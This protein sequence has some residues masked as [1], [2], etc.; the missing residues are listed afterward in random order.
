MNFI[1]IILRKYS[2]NSKILFTNTDNLM[3][4]IKS[5]NVYEEFSNDKELFDFSYYPSK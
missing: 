5:E 2:N 3:Y 4:E 1:M